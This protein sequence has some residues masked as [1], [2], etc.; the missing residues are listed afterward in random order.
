[1]ESTQ[2]GFTVD[3]LA[4]FDRIRLQQQQNRKQ[5]TRNKRG[6]KG[7]RRWGFATQGGKRKRD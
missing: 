5:Q 2:G 4:E 7:S 1:V 6:N 3:E